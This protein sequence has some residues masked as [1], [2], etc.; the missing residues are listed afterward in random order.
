[1]GAGPAL[2]LLHGTGS[3]THSWRALAP[4]LAKS[5]AVVAF[6]LPGHGFTQAVAPQRMS[7]P[8][9]ASAVGALLRTLEIEP[10]IVLGHSAGAAIAI[11]MDL[12]RLVAPRLLIAVNGALLPLHGWPGRIFSPAAKLLAATAITPRLFAWHASDPR[13]VERLIR[14]TGSVIEPEGMALYRRLVSNARH[15]EGALDMMANWDLSALERDLHRL[16]TALVLVVGSND[17]TVDPEHARRV[18]A[19][20]P[21]T[22]IVTIPGLGHLAHEERPDQVAALIE[23]LAR[24]CRLI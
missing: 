23:R 2:V 6:D 4:L 21:D 20:L 10:A 1:M 18:R 19:A 17:R 9:V 5:F 3:G 24:A 14:S 11:R 15:V 8:A 12:D 7:L 13:T 16:R 22:S